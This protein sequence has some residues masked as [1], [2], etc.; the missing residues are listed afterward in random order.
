MKTSLFFK[1][2]LAVFA[3]ILYSNVTRASYT[4]V[5]SGNW[6][7]SA[8]WGGTSPGSNVSGQ[9]IVIPNGITVGLDIDVVFSGISNSF[10]VNGNLANGGMTGVT[11]TQGSL[12]G[13]GSVTIN[14][15]TFTSLGNA[16]AFT[17]NMSLSLFENRG[18]TLTLAAMISVTDTLNMDAGSMLLNAGANLILQANSTVLV[19]NGSLSVHGGVFN[20]IYAYNV[21]YTGSSKATGI[22]LNT[23]FLNRLY[24]R[25]SDN[26]QTLT[27]GNDLLVSG[28]LS[29]STGIF[30]FSGQK[31]TLLS[32]LNTGAGA[33]LAS[34]ST[35]VL[36]MLS[37]EP[38]T[39]GFYFTSGSSLQEWS[40]NL[41]NSA[42]VKLYT[43]LSLTGSL[44]LLAGPLSLETGAALATSAGA[45]IHIESGILISNGGS[46][47]G[48]ASYDVEYMGG[49]MTGGAELTGT[50][51]R[52]LTV[53]LNTASGGQVTL[54]A[55]TSIAGRLNLA[56]GNL[57][58]HGFNLLLNGTFQ[59]SGTGSFIGHKN[60]ELDLN[61]TASSGSAITFD[62]SNQNLNILQINI[63][64]GGSVSLGSALTISGNLNFGNGVLD[65]ANSDLLIQGSAT[66]N[67]YSDTRYILTSGTG[68]LFLYVNA[69]G[70]ASVAPIGTAT[71]FAPV[72]LLQS[73]AGSSAYFMVR[74]EDGVFAQG[75][76]GFNSASIA[77]VV[78]HTWFVEASSGTT[79]D[80]SLQ[81]SWTVAAEL[82]GFNRT[83]AFISHYMASHWDAYAFASASAGSNNTYGLMR[84][85]ITTLSPFTVADNQAALGIQTLA[86]PHIEFYPNP[87]SSEINI[88]LEGNTAYWSYEILDVTGKIQMSTINN[89]SFNRFTIGA[90]PNG[91]YF[92]RITNPENHRTLVKRF[93]K[94]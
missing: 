91:S 89:E 22:E 90:L 94:I 23:L 76:S 50:G 48:T 61:L 45:M 81:L 35:S 39:S 83:Q 64:G 15:L 21:V 44:K 60:S 79:V 54:A 37:A 56:N 27:L 74:A 28:A 33:S 18:A 26:T 43:A 24:I 59:S 41:S 32:Y 78:N 7:S 85:G 34:S 69:G 9:D 8:T 49:S 82:N 11:I 20:N 75:T 42:K 57:D 66:I 47:N 62:A 31:L 65:I 30:D 19:N 13:S 14:R 77:S 5:A 63:T 58:L 88:E 29:L 36:T 4:A 10:T 71:G 1:T 25:M 68:R 72:G 40:I 55:N 53:S 17:G 67:A 84:T 93:V 38:V 46:F 52:N 80:L 51:L 2:G 6:S 16:A 73:A 86:L 70:P 92:L 3:F 87:A 12:A